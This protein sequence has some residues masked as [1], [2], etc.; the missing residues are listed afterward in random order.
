MR[1]LDLLVVV[2]YLVAIAMIGL[3]PAGRQRTAKD[4]FVGEGHMPFDVRSHWRSAKVL[5]DG[6]RVRLLPGLTVRQANVR[7]ARY[8]R[9]LG[10]DPASESACTIG[11]PTTSPVAA[12]PALR[13]S[14]PP[15]RR[16]C[17]SPHVSAASSPRRAPRAVRRPRS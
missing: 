17:S 1:Q 8:G 13:P 16:R 9:R 10:P 12:P 7:L 14:G 11:G 6:L 15:R 5:D 2:V 3:R 4:Y